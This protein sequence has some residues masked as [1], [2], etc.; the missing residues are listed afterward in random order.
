MM[1]LYQTLDQNIHKMLQIILCM[2]SLLP[3]LQTSIHNRALSSESSLLPSFFDSIQDIYV[4]LYPVIGKLCEEFRK[5]Q[6]LIKFELLD[7]LISIVSTFGSQNIP[8][9]PVPGMP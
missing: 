4:D 2:S 8:S 7:V 3:S 6:D 5:R 9:D 1:F